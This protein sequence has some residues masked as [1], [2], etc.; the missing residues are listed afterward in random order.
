MGGG[1]INDLANTLR[2][3]AEHMDPALVSDPQYITKGETWISMEER[4]PGGRYRHGLAKLAD[5]WGKIDPSE[6]L[7]GRV[8]PVGQLPVTFLFECLHSL[9]WWKIWLPRTNS[10]FL[11]KA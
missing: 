7:L 11:Q 6:R 5:S 8:R 3:M 10:V 9:I 4:Q 2:T 1:W